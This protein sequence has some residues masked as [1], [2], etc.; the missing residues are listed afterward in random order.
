V[1]VV[2]IGTAVVVV[3]VATLLALSLGFFR[4]QTLR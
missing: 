4:T 2:E 3:L 1:V